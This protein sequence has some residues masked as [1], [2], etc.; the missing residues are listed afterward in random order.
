VRTLRDL[1]YTLVSL[2]RYS[3]A[4]AAHDRGLALAP[5][6]LALLE[7]KA[8]AHLGQGDLAGA[9]AVIRSA[10]K[11]VEP[12]ALVAYF[13]LYQDLVW[14]LD[15][16]QQ[17]LLLRLTP[18]EFGND[19]GGWGLVLAQTY[20]FRGNDAKARAYADSA[21]LGFEEHLRATPEDAQ[22][23]GLLGLSLAYLGRKAEAIREG[24]RGV[25]I[26]PIARDAANF[27]PYLQHQLAR[28]YMLTG[29]PDK[30]LDALEPLLKIPYVLSPGWLKIDPNFE[31]LRGNPRF[32]RLVNGS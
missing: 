17:R 24:E 21:R 28:I 10:P 11:E 14:A 23:H 9:R 16:D 30:A 22:Q 29:E 13:A 2:R 3:E 20:H 8:M 31:P 1:A 12:T 6:N 15:D 32:E 26:T 7:G 4:L 27:G 25:A 18:S 19:R 5:T